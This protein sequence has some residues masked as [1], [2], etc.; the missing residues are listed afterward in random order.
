LILFVM[1]LFVVNVRAQEPAGDAPAE[2]EAAKADA[3][4]APADETKPDEKLEEEIDGEGTADPEAL[5]Q[6]ADITTFIH[7][8]ESPDRK[9]PIGGEVHALIGIHNGGKNPFNVSYIGAS[10]HSPFQL[11]YYIQNFSVRS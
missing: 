11:D 1:A 3:E 5:K 8:P 6:S 9:L 2:G 7:F 10:L 4:A